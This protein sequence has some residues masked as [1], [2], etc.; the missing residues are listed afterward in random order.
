[1]ITDGRTCWMLCT[2]ELVSSPTVAGKS[3]FLLLKSLYSSESDSSDSWG[4]SFALFL[5]FLETFSVREPFSRVRGGWKTTINK[6]TYSKL[7]S[8]HF[9]SLFIVM[10]YRMLKDKPV[11]YWWWRRRLLMVPKYQIHLIVP[12]RSTEKPH[13]KCYQNPVNVCLMLIIVANF[14]LITIKCNLL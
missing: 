5:E 13:V 8:F 6:K 14:S 4:R 9:H 7:S 3:V 2:A 12:P 11:Q 10:Q 1:M